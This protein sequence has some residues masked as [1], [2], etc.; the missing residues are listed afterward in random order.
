MDEMVVTLKTEQA[1]DDNKK[2]Y[3][4]KQFDQSDDKKKGLERQ[5]SDLETAI[6]DAE[7]GIA[8]T[9][10]EIEALEDSIKAL[11][12]SVAEATEQRKEENEDY[13]ELMASDT[14]CK[15]LIGVA[16]NRLNK[17]YNPKLYKPP[18]KRELTEE[19]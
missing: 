11:D 1:D 18:P 7:E 17:F 3:C 5:I 15:G 19:E 12:K 10:S 14:A 16:K 9:K 8:T 13:T 4:A 2:E 6:E